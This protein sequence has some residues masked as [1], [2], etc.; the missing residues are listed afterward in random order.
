MGRR[1]ARPQGHQARV[2]GART[3]TIGGRYASADERPGAP[4]SCG[5]GQPVRCR[6]RPLPVHPGLLPV[7]GD[8]PRRHRPAWRAV[9]R[10]SGV[11]GSPLGSDCRPFPLAT[12]RD[13][14]R[15]SRRL[16]VGCPA[17]R[18]QSAAAAG[19]RRGGSGPVH[20]RHFSDPGRSCPGGGRRR[21]QP[22]QPAAG[23][24]I[25]FLHRQ[26][27]ARRLA[28]RPDPDH[29]HVR[30]ARRCFAG[31]RPD[32]PHLPRSDRRHDGRPAPDRHRGCSPAQPDSRSVP[33][34]HPP[35]LELEHGHQR[36]LL[37][38]PGRD[39]GGGCADRRCLGDR[40]AGR[41]PVMLGYPRLG[42]RFGVE[43]LLLVGAAVFLVRAIAVLVLRDP[44]SSP[45]PWRCTASGSRWCWSAASST[46]RAM[47]PR[48]RPPLPRAC[49]A[50][51]CSESRPSSAPVLVVCW[52]AGWGCRACS[53]WPPSAAAWRSWRW[54]G[55]CDARRSSGTDPGALT[56]V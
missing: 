50:Q 42:G 44:C 38:P 53:R 23:L 26:R 51:S 17:C 9:R 21:P 6:R 39:R 19:A 46:S 3:D 1:V 28:D 54:P 16:G 22:L 48:A 47:H 11:G 32:R 43:R 4:G 15:G 8:R 52:R 37:H 36:F 56:V 13:A 5:D 33:S 25:G 20:G 34:G 40:G 2:A 24:G 45:P 49:S 10:G 18:R 41:V 7:P 35:G 30:G 12:H 55:R 27:A 31:N 29:G 14:G